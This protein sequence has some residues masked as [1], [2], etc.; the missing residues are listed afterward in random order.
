M[1]ASWHFVQA[2]KSI[3]QRRGI[4]GVLY[5]TNLLAAVALTLPLNR[6]LRE[7]GT[8]T[9]AEDFIEAVSLEHIGDILEHLGAYLPAVFIYTLLFGAFYVLLNTFFAGGILALLHRESAFAL[10]TFL[11]ECASYFGRFFRLFLLFVIVATAVVLL[12]LLPAAAVIE[13]FS[14]IWSE[15]QQFYATLIAAALAVVLLALVMMLFDYAK[16]AIVVQ[17]RGSVLGGFREGARFA[18]SRFRTAAALFTLNASIIVLLALLYWAV[19]RLLNPTTLGGILALAILQQ[20][21]VLARLW[22]RVS[23]F[24]SQQHFFTYVP[25]PSNRIFDLFA[26]TPVRQ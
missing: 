14:P 4:V 9:L 26:R 24:A 22:M 2:Q 23:F 17:D 6:V 11:Q 15:R 8:T 16:I 20:L 18:F 19:D 21:F 3:L 12:Y 5:L 10:R 13:F 25:P 7:V 1:K